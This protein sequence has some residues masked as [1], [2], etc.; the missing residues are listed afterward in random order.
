MEWDIRSFSIHVADKSSW[1]WCNMLFNITSDH[2][3]SKRGPVLCTAG[4][5]NNTLRGQAWKIPQAI[6][7]FPAVFFFFLPRS[8][9][10]RP[11]GIPLSFTVMLRHNHFP[12]SAARARGAGGGSLSLIHVSSSC[13]RH[14]DKRL[15]PSMGARVKLRLPA[16]CPSSNIEET[17][18]VLERRL[19]W[20]FIFQDF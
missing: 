5:L 18:F 1:C 17:G 7:Y 13:K 6:I 9:P 20:R 3:Q 8:F 14:P 10:L 16:R 11:G 15:T 2:R 4:A 19:T 12:R